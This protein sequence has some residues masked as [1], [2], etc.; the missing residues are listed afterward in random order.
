MKRLYTKAGYVNWEAVLNRGF[1]FTFCVGGRGTGKTYGLL[2]YCVEN[3]IRFIYLRRTQ[4]QL[5]IIHKPEFSPFKPINEDKGLNIQPIK[6]TKDNSA[7]YNCIIDEKGKYLPQ[8]DLLGYTA[9]LSTF[10]S[11]RSFDAS[12]VDMIIYDEFIPERH[13]KRIKHEASAFFNAIETVNRNRELKGKPFTNVV[14]L[15]N[16]NDAANPLFMELELVDIALKQIDNRT[17]VYTDVNRGL[18]LINLLKSPIS[19]E[20][21]NTALYRLTHNTSFY[22]MAVSNDYVYNI[23]S[24]IGSKILIQY[25]PIIQI[26]EICIYKHKSDLEYYVTKHKSGTI[27]YYNTDDTSLLR[28]RRRYRHIV[29]AYLQNKV[30]FENYHCEVLFS[31]YLVDN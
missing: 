12:D 10:S 8:G 31:R 22:N 26:G 2:N 5:D 17:E 21:Q 30:V 4:K 18:L 19:K 3:K 20:K 16:S 13:E 6:F 14:C 24:N 28:V 27:P 15:A 9:A 11:L 25:V 29:I 7:F 1:P 23:P